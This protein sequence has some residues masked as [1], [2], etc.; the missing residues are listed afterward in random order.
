M[1]GLVILSDLS[2]SV[3]HVFKTDK[4]ALYFGFIIAKYLFGQYI[5]SWISK[6]IFLNSEIFCN[7]INLHMQITSLT[8]RII[9]SSSMSI[10]SGSGMYGSITSKDLPGLAQQSAGVAAPPARAGSPARG[11]SRSRSK[12]IIE[13][14]D[15]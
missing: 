6:Y 1:S 4:I 3:L 10:G 15:P 11:R 14:L 8:A 9:C 12:V 13:I 2:I 7:Y 5:I